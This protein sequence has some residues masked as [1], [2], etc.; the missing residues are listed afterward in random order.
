MNLRRSAVHLSTVI[1]ANVGTQCLA[2]AGM[3]VSQEQS[4]WVPAFAG[5][6]SDTEMMIGGMPR[7]EGRS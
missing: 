5:M 2:C 6:T 4:R 3:I 7:A 1:P